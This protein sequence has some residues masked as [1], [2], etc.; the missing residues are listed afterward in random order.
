M[1]RCP[2]NYSLRAWLLGNAASYISL[3]CA[4]KLLLLIT[5]DRF[6]PEARGLQLARPQP[7]LASHPIKH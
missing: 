5:L 6:D 3:V 7:W 1:D 4:V 2:A